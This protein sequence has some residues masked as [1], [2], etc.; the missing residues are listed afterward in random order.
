MKVVGYLDKVVDWTLG[1]VGGLRFFDVVGAN[2]WRGSAVAR[3]PVLCGRLRCVGVKQHRKTPTFMFEGG[4]TMNAR[5]VEDFW[6]NAPPEVRAGGEGLF[7]FTKTGS[8][9]NV[10]HLG[11][12]AWTPCEVPE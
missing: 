1:D 8:A 10:V 6:V 2:P 5:A 7:T 12:R 4:L 3:V 11:K 9:L